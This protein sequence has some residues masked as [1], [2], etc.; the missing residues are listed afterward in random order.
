MHVVE[1]HMQVPSWDPRAAESTME[2]CALPSPQKSFKIA[3]HKTK[4]CLTCNRELCLQGGKDSDPLPLHL[5]PA[6]G[7]GVSGVGR[8]GGRHLH[9]LCSSGC[10][11]R[12]HCFYKGFWS[13]PAG[14]HP[15]THVPSSASQLLR[16]GFYVPGI[17]VYGFLLYSYFLFTRFSPLSLLFLLNFD[18]P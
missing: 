15:K 14:S 12:K 10:L 1:G 2:H 4:S 17:D 8:W 9:G 7:A 6:S 13:P 16:S 5:T 3:P 11:H 18:D